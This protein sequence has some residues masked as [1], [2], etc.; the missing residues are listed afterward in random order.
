MTILEI[1]KEE[2][3]KKYPNFE[4][5]INK[6][7][8]FTDLYSSELGLKNEVNKIIEEIQIDKYWIND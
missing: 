6:C 3:T 8:K 4:K 7:K 1:V 5:T 2:L